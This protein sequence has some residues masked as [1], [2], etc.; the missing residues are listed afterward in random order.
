MTGSGKNLVNPRHGWMKD[1]KL[2]E[3]LGE[4]GK[5]GRQAVR[6]DE[7][8]AL[9]QRSMVLA[10]EIARREAEKAAGA[11]S[12]LY[13]AGT[14]NIGDD[15]IQS[16]NTQANPVT[17]YSNSVAG[18]E[19]GGFLALFSGYFDNTN[20]PDAFGNIQLFIDGV[21]VAEHRVGIRT[22]GADNLSGMIPFTLAGVFSTQGVTPTLEVKAF[23]SNWD[24]ETTANAGFYIRKSRLV[25]SGAT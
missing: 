21:E 19:D 1:A 20:T 9:V 6:H 16:T 24:D 11:A 18:F 8:D 23:A 4:R 7:V 2:E 12:T 5:K 17:I 25:I 14:T 22:S 15:P 10:R 3:L 13:G